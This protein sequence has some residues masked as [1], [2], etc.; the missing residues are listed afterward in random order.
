MEGY[1]DMEKGNRSEDV[2]LS[3]WYFHSEGE[4]CHD[5][6]P[7]SINLLNVEGKIFCQFQSVFLMS[8]G[9]IFLRVGKEVGHLLEGK[10][11]ES[12]FLCRKQD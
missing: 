2:A 3:R 12:I 7:V 4:Q 1:G 9:K 5:Y 6:G 10:S 8:K 11:F